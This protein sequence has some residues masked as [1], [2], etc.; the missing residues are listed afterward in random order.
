LDFG[1]VGHLSGPRKT[2]LEALLMALSSRDVDEMTDIVIDIT[3][4]PADIDTDRLSGQLETWLSRYLGGNVADL[5]LVGMVNSGMQI[6]HSNRLTFPSDLSLLFRVLV[7]LQGLGSSVGA[8]VS[9]T[10]LLQPY[11]EEMTGFGG[12]PSP[13]HPARLGASTRHGTLEAP[14]GPPPTPRRNNRCR[15]PNPRRRWGNRPTHRRHPGS[16][17]YFRLSRTHR[18]ADRSTD[19]GRVHPRSGRGHRWCGH[20]A[21]PDSQ[22]RRPPQQ[23]QP[24]PPARPAVTKEWGSPKLDDLNRLTRRALPIDGRY[25]STMRG[26]S[27]H[28]ITVCRSRRGGTSAGRAERAR[29]EAWSHEEYLVACLQR[30][31]P[32]PARPPAAKV[33]SAP[34]V[35]PAAKHG[36]R[37]QT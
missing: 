21:T 27:N 19:P 11:W 2:Q 17:L 37:T 35:S 10:E 24:H 15:I 7:Q 6:M 18:P 1:D 9:L 23:H 29:T 33:G 3:D 4:A 20:L 25:T 31:I 12:P 14:A 36:G 30:E 32:A 8:K 13:P 16:G 5:D 34:P 28:A 22:S 26:R